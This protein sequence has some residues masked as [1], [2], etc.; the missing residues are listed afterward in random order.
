MCT[1]EEP[2]FSER[3][4]PPAL[5]FV[6]LAAIALAQAVVLAVGVRAHARPV[7]PAVLALGVVAGVVLPLLLMT[8]H[9]VVSV[10]QEELWLAL[11][12]VW[13][14][15]VPLQ[16]IVS[17]E[18]IDVSPLRDTG[19]YGLR[20][21]GRGLVAVVMRRGRAVEVRTVT[22]ERYVIGS[23]RPEQLRRALSE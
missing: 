9:V 18:V 12:P 22:G 21:G 15:T 17:V 14:R 1:D 7:S 4:Y 23:R 5:F 19:G 8:L 3:S 2:R 10:T 11:P 16:R 13:R 6:V 20:F